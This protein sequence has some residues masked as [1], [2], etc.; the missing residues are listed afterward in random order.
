MREAPR[1]TGV[2]TEVNKP[3]RWLARALPA[4]TWLR[5]YSRS[6]FQ[7]DT[8]AGLITAILL[9]PQAMAYGMLAGLPPQVGLYA[10]V[11]APIAYALFGSSRTLAV[12]PVA[13]AAVMVAGALASQTQGTP[14]GNALVLALE[15]GLILLVMAALRLGA[16]VNFL[17]HPVL[18][19]FT[20]GAAILILLT[21]IPPLLGIDA[22]HGMTTQG[23][24]KTVYG[25]L[26]DVAPA[27]LALG[28]T[29]IALLLFAGGPLRLLL[30]KWSGSEAATLLARAGPLVVVFLALLAVVALD[31][32]GS[33]GVAT[34]GPIPAGLP[35]L[36]LGFLRLGTWVA[37][38]PSALLIALIAY[39]ESVSMAKI[40]ANRRRQ[41]ISANRELTALGAANV[42]AAFTGGM[43]VAGSFSRTMVNF[44]AGAR[45]QIAG[46]VGALVIGLT[47]L[48]FAPWFERLPTA[49][50]AAIIVVAVL[51]LID[52]AGVRALWRYQRSDAA[53][54]LLT[55]VGVLVFGIEVGLVIGLVVSLL[56][57]IWRTSHPHVAVVGRIPGTEHFRNVLRH[58]VETW[59][60]LALIRVDESLNFANIGV[61][62]DFIMAHLAKHPR[63]E[64]LV[65]ICSAVNHIDSSALETLERLVV[66]L[67]EAGV[68]VHLS[69]VKGP[70]MD[71]LERVDLPARMAP[72]R[73]FFRTDEAITHLAR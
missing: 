27:T 50:L 52:P 72:G 57:Y 38:F 43:P 55:L 36:D 25:Q 15:I 17:S 44:A 22:G 19:G 53:T 26:G 45:T 12:G 9:V 5:G 8:I 54:L 18:S 23:I 65:L 42:V 34:V 31:L 49:T 4:L 28:V 69:V 62:E 64:H 60:T 20:S 24:A 56:A 73:I 71:A 70:V 7:A 46:I 3:A 51:P 58:D 41:R 68:T 13:V 14:V 35:S 67:R 47:L 32:D 16:M 30:R 6:D 61:V 48:F 37:L 39:V 63:V 2:S 1:G 40:L 11:V 33:R 21:Q 10:S 66:N 29:S 59:P